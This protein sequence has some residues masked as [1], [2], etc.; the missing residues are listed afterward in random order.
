VE[1]F[2]DYEDGLIAFVANVFPQVTARKAYQGWKACVEGFTEYTEAGRHSEAHP[3]VQNRKALHDSYGFS[4][5][6]QAKLDLGLAFAFGTNAGITSFWLLNHIFSSHTLLAEIRTELTSHAL[7]APN[8]LSL[9]KLRDCPLL[10]SVYRETLRMVAPMTSARFVR[11]DT[12][13]ADRYL[14]RKGSVVQIAGNVM[15]SSPSIWGA[16]A[17]TFN[18]RRFLHSTAGSKADADGDGGADPSKPSAV[19]PAAFRSFGGGAS[20]CPGRH[21]AQMEILGFCAMLVLG[22]EMLPVRGESGVG[23]D[24]EMDCK[25][26]LLV[27]RKPQREVKVQ[28][29]RRS[30]FEGVEWAVV[31]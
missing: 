18:A 7:T 11:S 31:E 21:F 23:W 6:E 24:P 12:V 4:S 25:A 15:H 3:I 5:R 19:H 22:F 13:L 17:T 16:D 29:R 1:S 14:L 9:R 2:W 30:G 26:L 27:V 10:N 8:T 28:M 20:L